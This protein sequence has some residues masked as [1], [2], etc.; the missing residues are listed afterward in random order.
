MKTLGL[1]LILA[2]P[3]YAADPLDDWRC[4]APLPDHGQLFDCV[5]F[6]N[7]LFIAAGFGVLSVS[8]DGL[9]WTNQS[10]GTPYEIQGIAYGNGSF[11]GVGTGRSFTS[12]QTFAVV[13]TSPD[14]I[15]WTEQAHPATMTSLSSI[16]F[17]AG[18]FVAVGQRGLGNAML[19][20]TNGVNWTVRNTSGANEHGRL[21]NDWQAVTFGYGKFV[22]TGFNYDYE[23]GGHAPISTSPDGITWYRRDSHSSPY[24]GMSSVIY[25]DGKFVAVGS[26]V[27]TSLDGVSWTRAAERASFDDSVAFGKNLFVTVGA[28]IRTSPD[29]MTWTEQASPTTYFL[30]SVTHGN[31]M[32]VA[33]G[34]GVMLVSTNAV[35]WIPLVD[36]GTPTSLAGVA[37]GGGQFVAV[38]YGGRVLHSPDGA[39]W[40]STVSGTSNYL[41]DVI[42]AANMF[43]AVGSHG[44]LLTSS[45]GI[46]WAAIHTGFT[47]AFNAVGYGNGFFVAASPDYGV[48]LTSSNAVDWLQHDLGYSFPMF[49]IA[50]GNSTFVGTGSF[51]GTVTT[52]SDGV[53]WT[54]RNTG[55]TNTPMAVGFGNGMFVLLGTGFAQTSTNGVDWSAPRFLPPWYLPRRAVYAHGKFVCVG[56]YG[57]IATSTNGLD[58]TTRNS[59]TATRLWS[60]AYGQRTVVALGDYGTILQSA[61]F[62]LSPAYLTSSGTPQYPPFRLV[63]SGTSG[64]LWHLQASADLS[65]WSPLT[66]LLLISNSAEFLDYSVTNLSRRFYRAVSP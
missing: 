58:W 29:G 28:T 13:M 41:G 62:D 31:G 59:G 36:S 54:G 32:F 50:F 46:D 22:A 12:E 60:V 10:P 39:Q 51:A 17:G 35:D 64:E 8:S 6:Q 11:V 43:V 20:S 52:S 19:T 44:T 15:H 2:V 40:T 33:A 34:W 7:G 48:F 24:T 57:L 27:L 14:G 55:A 56:D 37:Y 4:R 30:K 66:D 1:A 38:G 63:L 65:D 21:T 61:S 9:H 5:T 26:E 49:T 18:R 47:N 42:W 3:L 53:H 16:A 23:S 45:N 25:G